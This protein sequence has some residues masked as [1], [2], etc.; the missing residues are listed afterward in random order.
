M[1]LSAD[2]CAMCDIGEGF[3][4][5]YRFTLSSRATWRC[6]QGKSRLVAWSRA[7]RIA[8]STLKRL[9]GRLPVGRQGG[10]SK[11]R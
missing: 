10:F 3:T 4:L 8:Q 5:N 1:S 2:K 11:T 6:E 7:E 9:R